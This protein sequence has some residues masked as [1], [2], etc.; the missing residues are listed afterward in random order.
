[1]INKF[2]ECA[3]V[4]LLYKYNDKYCPIKVT[5]STNINRKQLQHK[6][7][8]MQIPKYQTE[9]KLYYMSQVSV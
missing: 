5:V 7:L 8:V 4:G 2:Y 3:F 9:V 1:M 6:S